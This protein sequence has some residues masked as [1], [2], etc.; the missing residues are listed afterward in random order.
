MRLGVDISHW[1]KNLILEQNYY[2]LPFMMVK[3][4]E[5]KS[6]VDPEGFDYLAGFL[7]AHKDA[8][9]KTFFGFYHFAHAESN[10]A[11]DEAHHFIRTVNKWLM[12]AAEQL[13][14]VGE[15]KF[16]YALD[17]EAKSLTISDGSLC[18]W[19]ATFAE[20]CKQEWGAEMLLY[21]SASVVKRLGMYIT[22][23]SDDL[24]FIW[25]AH[26]NV[27]NPK[28]H[29]DKRHYGMWQFTSKPLDIDIAYDSL[30]QHLDKFAIKVLL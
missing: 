28:L 6:V 16:V 26:Y 10:N 4:T 20:V 25:I 21:V 2:D 12:C 24:P 19:I 30:F 17:V 11:V 7:N 18:K 3:A 27:N 23:Q 22:A 13:D 9:D 5:G 29:T 8:D 14:L 15:H 1:N